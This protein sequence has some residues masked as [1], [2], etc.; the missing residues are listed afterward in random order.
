MPMIVSNDSLPIRIEFKCSFC[1]VLLHSFL[2][3]FICIILCYAFVANTL[4]IA[5]HNEIGAICV[6]LRRLRRRRRHHRRRSCGRAIPLSTTTATL[7]HHDDDVRVLNI[8]ELRP[9]GAM[10]PRS[11]CNHRIMVLNY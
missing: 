7:W 10:A 8:I 2:F 3:C 6:R 9:H 1:F 11:R 4:K 5:N